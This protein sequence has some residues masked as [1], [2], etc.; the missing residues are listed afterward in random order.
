MTINPRSLVLVALGTGAAVAVWASLPRTG[1]GEVR[2]PGHAESS[3]V[4]TQTKGTPVGMTGCLAAACHGGPATDVLTGNLDPATWRGSG[5]AW[6]AVDPHAAAY[7]ALEGESARA[8]V[9]KLR[10]GVAATEDARCL[11]CHTNPALAAPAATPD[12]R[13][14]EL[15]REGVSCEACHGNAGGWLREHTTWGRQTSGA[16]FGMTPLQD[17]GVRAATCVGCHV[18]A[19]A[20][21]DRGYPARDMNHDMIAAGHPRLN[22]DFG[23]YHRRLPKHWHDGE[24]GAQYEARLWWVGRVAHAEAACR[25][26][27]DRAERS[28]DDGRTPWP[29]YAEFRCDACHH[30]IPDPERVTRVGVRPAGSPPWQTLWPLRVAPVREVME[31]GRPP[32][33]ARIIPLARNEARELAAGLP[34]VAGMS[35]AAVRKQTMEL[36]LQAEVTGN[37]RDELGQMLLGLAAHERTRL[38]TDRRKPDDFRRVIDP[39]RLNDLK[40]AREALDGIWRRELP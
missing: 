1:R 22:F 33:P 11:A 21:P 37:D 38:P 39:L 17:V 5:S 25:L 23:E 40:A 31:G 2:V 4:A 18:G 27:A 13:V 28:A 8:I 10:T 36:L 3:G 34:K 19:P 26:L 12:P 16:G 29:E 20:D 15:R 14:P 6:V 9:A 24:R 32:S 30:K 35:D 7:R